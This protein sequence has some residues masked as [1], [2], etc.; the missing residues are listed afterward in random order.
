M[1]TIILGTVFIVS[2]GLYFM[3]RGRRRLSRN[4]QYLS[5]SGL[6]WL[7]AQIPAR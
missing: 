4:E 7:R 1:S 5:P 3:G 6:R 2:L